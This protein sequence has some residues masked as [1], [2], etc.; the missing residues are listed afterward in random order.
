MSLHRP[1]LAYLS[2][3]VILAALILPEAYWKW[4]ES[5]TFGALDVP[6]TLSKGEIRTPDFPINLKGWYHVVLWVDGDLSGCQ[7]GLSHRALV[8][9]STIYDH[10]NVI[11]SSEGRDRY[12]GHFY[13]AKNG[14]YSVA[15]E[16]LSDPACLNAGHPRKGVWSESSSYVQLYNELCN[17]GILIAII[18]VGL[19]VFSFS[20]TGRVV[21][22]F[23]EAPVRML[24]PFASEASLKME[25]GTHE[26]VEVRRQRR[27]PLRRKFTVLP[28]RGL[29]GGMMV[30][31]LLIPVSILVNQH[32]LAMGIYVR[33]VPR[34]H[35]GPDENCLEGPIIV[36]VKRYGGVI[37]LFLNGT[38]VGRE[39]LAPALASKLAW[40]ANWEVF[41]E[42]DDSAPY[43][44]PM[45]VIDVIN[46]I[47]AK[48]VI[49]TPKL[50]EEMAKAC[51]SR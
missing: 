34:H 3:T 1:R 28:N 25:E 9:R 18:C 11:E 51:V 50:K 49:L 37:Q 32:D 19:L 46:S 40:R 35:S 42:G 15:V 27:L 44:E 12:L 5:R 20:S 13:A 29:V 38:K 36:T 30:L 4:L 33:L 43:L 26:S 41:V 7:D 22:L 48:A 47:H 31:I 23:A 8:S 45:F 6:V 14:R 10:G 16:I 24:P 2:A 21:A 39:Q 17:I